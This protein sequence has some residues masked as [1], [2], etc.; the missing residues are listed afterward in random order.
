MIREFS[1][2]DYE[3]VSM[4]WKSQGGFHEELDGRSLILRALKRNPSL[5]L[6]AEEGG[7]IIGTAFASFDGRLGLIYRMVVH[8]DHRRKGIASALMAEI[9]KRLSGLGCQITGLLVLHDNTVAINMYKRR[10]YTL[11]PKVSYMYK[12]F[13]GQR[14]SKGGPKNRYRP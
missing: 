5:L 8:P 6:V 3:Q 1:P 14:M 11:L 2:T 7:K 9:E 13:T 10:G 12:E 4:L